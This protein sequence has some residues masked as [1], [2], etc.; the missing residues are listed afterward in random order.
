MNDKSDVE[1]IEFTTHPLGELLSINIHLKDDE[2][3]LLKADWG[4][5][6]GCQ[7][8]LVESG[9]TGLNIHIPW[10]LRTPGEE[11]PEPEEWDDWNYTTSEEYDN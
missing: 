8:P 6:S 1:F 4:N 2:M 3:K 11:T 7:P 5:V 9:R 10:I